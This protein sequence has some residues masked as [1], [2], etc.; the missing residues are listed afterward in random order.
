MDVDRLR[1]RRESLQAG[2]RAE[3]VF[4]PLLAT[5]EV[6]LDEAHSAFDA[7]SAEV[8]MLAPGCA[9]R[10]GRVI[11]HPTVRARLAG[12]PRSLAGEVHRGI[13]IGSH[14]IPQIERRPADRLPA[15][16][17]RRHRPALFILEVPSFRVRPRSTIHLSHEIANRATA[18]IGDDHRQRALLRLCV[19]DRERLNALRPGRG[20]RSLLQ[21]KNRIEAVDRRDGTVLASGHLQ[22]DGSGRYWRK[23]DESRRQFVVATTGTLMPDSELDGPPV[24]GRRET[25][26]AARIAAISEEVELVRVALEQQSVQSLRLVPRENVPSG[27]RGTDRPAQILLR[28]TGIGI[29]SGIRPGLAL[30]QSIR[31]TPKRS[32]LSDADSL[33]RDAVQSRLKQHPMSQ[34]RSRPRSTFG[35]Q[36][37]SR[38]KLRREDLPR[39]DHCPLLFVSGIRIPHDVGP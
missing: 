12:Q 25:R 34:R 11:G 26:I 35:Q 8:D 27:Q 7:G 33:R 16:L 37:G 19:P 13:G 14:L 21:I 20:N 9:R 5:V 38:P 28:R 4:R 3:I 22:L 15:I 6:T 17:T 30:R 1:I 36:Q 29:A 2:E 39:F 18:A 10:I 31:V 32:P 24:I 23:R